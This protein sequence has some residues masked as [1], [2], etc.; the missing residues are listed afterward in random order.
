MKFHRK[1]IA[2][3]VAVAS[4][5]CS[6]SA[7]ADWARSTDPLIVQPNPE[8]GAVQAQNPPSFFWARYPTGPATYDIE[9]TPSGG[10][11]LK[12]TVD[13]NWYLPTKAL[14]LGNYSWRVRPSGSSDWSSA[15]TF[16][17]TSKSTVFEVADNATL[18]ARIQAKARP[19][20]LPAS[21]TAYSTWN[22]AKKNDL[23]SYLSRLTN[24]IK[25]QTTAL[26]DLVDARWP[27]AILT[28]LTAAMASQQTDVRT[29][30]NEATRQLEAAALLWRAKKDPAFLNEAFK[31]GDQLVALNQGGRFPGRRPGCRPQGALARERARAL[32]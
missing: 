25:S 2:A 10:A 16:A 30:I 23:E 15:R 11:P 5:T 32:E 31:R 17:V 18:R 20:S 6:F 13:R 24:E 29:R 9:I 4:L 19:R 28:P 3:A 22:S 12:A 1:G 26:P 7:H 21:F 27:V 14:A 8:N